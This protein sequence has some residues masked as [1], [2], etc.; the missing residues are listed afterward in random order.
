MLIINSF[1]LR[2]INFLNFSN[3]VSLK[4]FVVCQEYHFATDRAFQKEMA[5][6]NVERMKAINW[7]NSLCQEKM[8]LEKVIAWREKAQA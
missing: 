6:L 3:D 2:S 1:T 7:R 5:Q 8:V 4:R